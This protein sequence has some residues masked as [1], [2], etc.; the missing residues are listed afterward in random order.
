MFNCTFC[1]SQTDDNGYFNHYGI[2]ETC[3][4]VQQLSNIYGMK[5]LLETLEIV[6]LRDPEPIAN[7]TKKIA[8]KVILRSG[9]EIDKHH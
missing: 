8:S 2:C 1:K 6:Y 3:E 5:Q 7:R 9:K 4:R